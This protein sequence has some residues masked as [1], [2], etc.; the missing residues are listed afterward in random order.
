MEIIRLVHKLGGMHYPTDLLGQQRYFAS[1]L[2][3]AQEELRAALSH[4]FTQLELD[5]LADVL[6][7]IVSPCEQRAWYEGEWH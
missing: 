1:D 6:A 2:P 4:E 5:C 3:A 7:D